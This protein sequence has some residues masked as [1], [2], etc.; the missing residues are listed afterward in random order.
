MQTKENYFLSQP[1]QPFFLLGIINA[2]VM[3]LIFALGYKGVLSLHGDSLTFH[4]YSL[5]FLVFTNFFTG[6]IFTTFPRFNQTQ[7][8][9]KKYYTNIFYANTLASLLFLV[10]AFSS[11]LLTLGA[12]LLSLI[13]QIFIVLKLKNIYETGMA[14]DKSDSFWILNAN[15]FGLFGNALFI[16]SFFVPAILPIAITISFY[17]YLIFFAFSVGQRMIPFF[18]H[19]FA[20]KNESFIKIIFI[21]FVLKSIF[22]SADIKSVQILVDLLLAG[23]MFLEFKRWD[24]HPFQSPPILW[25]LHLALFWLPVSFFLSALSLG[26]EIF[27]DTSFY[28][29]NIHLL[30]I[31]F[32]TT[33]LIGFGTRVTLGHSGQPPQADT[34]ATKI[35]LSI[36]MVVL[37]RALFSI[38]VAF[39]WGLNFLFDISFTAWLLLFLVWGGRYFKVLVFGSK[40]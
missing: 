9:E 8:I 34:L 17:M 22:A 19:S 15:Y 28:F 20:Q 30:A 24:L 6:F 25:I 36:Q 16:L 12:M 32:L 23:Y 10:G 33:L 38:N 27:L 26:A 13:A 31:G 35:F 39:G 21:L 29:L 7:V 1:H 2:I 3:M 11:E 4:S 40:L 5:I 37:L 14:P 18:S